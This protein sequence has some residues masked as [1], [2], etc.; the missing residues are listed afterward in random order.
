MYHI[1]VVQ[2]VIM[3]PAGESTPLI[4]KWSLLMLHHSLLTVSRVPIEASQT[5]VQKGD[6]AH[7]LD[8]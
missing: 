2:K 4:N 3:P 6:S 1:A 7:P 8:L 5:Q